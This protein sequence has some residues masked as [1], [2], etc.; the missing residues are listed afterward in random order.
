M[1]IAKEFKSVW[2]IVIPCWNN[3]IEQIASK[4][5]ELRSAFE[6]GGQIIEAY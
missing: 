1:T 5:L 2:S 6:Q 4:C 3:F